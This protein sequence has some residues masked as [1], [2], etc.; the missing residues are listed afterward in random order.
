[1]LHCLNARF[2]M[3]FLWSIAVVFASRSVLPAQ[4]LTDDIAAKNFARH[5]HL[6]DRYAAAEQAIRAFIRDNQQLLR[7]RGNE[8]LTIPVVVHVVFNNVTDNISDDQVRSQIE[9]LNRDY[10][11]RNINIANTPRDFR[12]LTADIGLEFCLASVDPEGR[13]TVGITR[14]QTGWTNIG[15]INSADGRRRVCYTSL[16]GQDAW[17]P[18]RYLNIWVARIGNGTLG[19][20]SYPESAM[21]AEDGVVIEPRYFGTRGTVVAPNDQGRTATHEVGHYFN[22]LHIWGRNTSNCTEDDLVEDTPSQREPFRGCPL[23]PQ[24]SCNNRSMF[25]NYMDYTDDGCMTLF[26]LGQRERMLAA[27]FLF[28]NELLS[29][30]GCGKGNVSTNTPQTD[31]SVALFPNP[32]TERLF[33]RTELANVLRAEVIVVDAL[34]RQWPVAAERTSAYVTAVPVNHLPAGHYALLLRLGRQQTTRH[35]VRS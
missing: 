1:M 24:I 18:K 7:E 13:P 31:L 21:E 10:R 23:F 8:I 6:A 3:L 11:M 17:E 27:L 30:G 22:L 19:Y 14:R 16:G 32:V 5:P 4:C 25:M 35:F 15:G 34:G 26:T 33:I 12:E 9:V 29:S 20:A 2:Y 28:R